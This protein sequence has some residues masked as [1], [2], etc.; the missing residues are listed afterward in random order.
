MYV[1]E[2]N[3]FA[4]FRL[5]QQVKERLQILRHCKFASAN[6]DTIIY[7]WIALKVPVPYF[8]A[9]SLTFPK[10]PDISRRP[11]PSGYKKSTRTHKSPDAYK[12][13]YS[14][15]VLF[16]ITVSKVFLAVAVTCWH[17]QPYQFVIHGGRIR[18]QHY[19]ALLLQL[20]QVRTYLRNL[21]IGN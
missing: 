8:P 17:S 13:N 16:R 11:F 1:C 5:C 20:F 4:V 3:V 2:R 15:G 19:L 21:L 6:L 12:D 7:C 18:R 14:D 10:Y 9:I